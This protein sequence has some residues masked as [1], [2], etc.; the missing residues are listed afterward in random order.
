V[1][2]Q[3]WTVQIGPERILI[4]GKRDTLIG[5]RRRMLLTGELVQFADGSQL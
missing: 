2:S 5:G 1:Y 3:R 4:I